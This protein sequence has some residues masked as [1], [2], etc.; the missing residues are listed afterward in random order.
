MVDAPGLRDLDEIQE[1]LGEII[2]KSRATKLV[3][4]DTQTFNP[5]IHLPADRFDEVLPTEAIEPGRPHNQMIGRP[6]SRPFSGQ[7]CPA[8]GAD[9]SHLIFLPIGPRCPPVEDVISG[10]MHEPQMM[11][12]G[13]ICEIA[14][15]FGIDTGSFFFCTFASIDGCKGGTI[16]Q[17][18][19]LCRRHPLL[20]R[21]G[22]TNIQEININ[23]LKGD[24]APGADFLDRP[25][26]LSF[27][28]GDQYLRHH[29]TPLE[30]VAGLDLFM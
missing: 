27:V 1:G 30:M 28:S 11:T 29:A 2:T 25:A 19:R 10:E 23:T 20:H 8:I 3:C 17:D 26:Q 7:F 4:N 12:R 6:S 14:N 9:W 21:S 18:I 5:G 13:G 15:C 24:T 22:I 16:D